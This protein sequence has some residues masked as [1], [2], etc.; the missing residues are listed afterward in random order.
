MAVP[1][2]RNARLPRLVESQ[3]I[4]H[5]PPSARHGKPW[6]QFAFWFGGNSNAFNAAAAGYLLLVSERG[7]AARMTTRENRLTL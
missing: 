1:A 5:I 6:H 3:H 7:S 4:D 2:A